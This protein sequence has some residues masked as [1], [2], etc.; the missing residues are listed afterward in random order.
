MD[1]SGNLSVRKCARFEIGK[2]AKQCAECDA[3][4]KRARETHNAPQ[5]TSHMPSNAMAWH[6]RGN[7]SAHRWARSIMIAHSPGYGLHR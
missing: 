2:E 1:P 4:A 3:L 5:M 7:P 6:G